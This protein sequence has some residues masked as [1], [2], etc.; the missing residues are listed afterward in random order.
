M[1]NTTPFQAIAAEVQLFNNIEQKK[2]F[3]FVVGALVSRL[4]SLQKGAEII[5]LEPEMFLKLLEVMN[6]EFSYLTPQDIEIE[7]SW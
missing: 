6:I 1:E 7:K 2:K 4:I 3:I 5:G